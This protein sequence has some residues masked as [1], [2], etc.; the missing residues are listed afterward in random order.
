LNQ[1]IS[2]NLR[3]NVWLVQLLFTT[4]NVIS[5]LPAFKAAVLV[6]HNRL[7]LFRTT[8]A[9]AIGSADRVVHVV[10]STR[11]PL[12]LRKLQNVRTQVLKA[13]RLK[14]FLKSTFS[15]YHSTL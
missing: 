5:L 9:I 4:G 14:V 13:K 3:Q 2:S 11:K 10:A 15:P 6:L 1:Q 8:V 7:K 12:I